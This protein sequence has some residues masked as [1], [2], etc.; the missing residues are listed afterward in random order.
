MRS[1]LLGLLIGL[2]LAAIIASIA[3]GREWSRSTAD[4]LN[5]G[6][7]VLVFSVLTWVVAHSIY[8]PGRIT[9]HRLQGAVVMYLSLATIFAIAFSLI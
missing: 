1:K 8:A 4:L 9:F 7:L 6:R 5:R 2:G 3:L